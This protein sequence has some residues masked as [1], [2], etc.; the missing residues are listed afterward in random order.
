MSFIRI[1][2]LLPKA[3]SR[4]DSKD[5]L[6]KKNHGEKI[7]KLFTLRFGQMEV[8][9]K[10][11]TLLIYGASPSKRQKIFLSKNKIITYLNAEAPEAPV[12]DIL[13]KVSR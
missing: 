13:F 12:R 8:E 7:T 5:T 4:I 6:K 3:I 1:K 2:S 9:Y 10:N 11:G